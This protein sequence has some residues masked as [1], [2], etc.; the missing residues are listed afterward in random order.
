MGDELSEPPQQLILDDAIFPR[1]SA[2]D[3]YG[4]VVVGLRCN[5]KVISRTAESKVVKLPDSGE[6][7]VIAGLAVDK[8]NNVYVVRWL[9]TRT[10]NSDVE[11]YCYVLNVLD[12][13]FNVKHDFRL[14]FLQDASL[15]Y[16]A[17][18]IA[19]NRNNNIIMMKGFDSNVCDNVGQL[20]HK[21]ESH[22]IDIGVI[23]LG[24]SNK[25]EIMIPSYVTSTPKMEI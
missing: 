6:G 8:N 5:I 20:K 13:N 18:E 4:N 15:G 24:I 3:S 16:V 14:D 25:D 17:V 11:C 7:K 19:I 23:M 2:V 9:T 22:D 12:E 21:F 1:L 10:E